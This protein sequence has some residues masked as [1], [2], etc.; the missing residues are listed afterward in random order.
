MP[1]SSLLVWLLAAGL[2]AALAAILLL[3]RQRQIARAVGARR[4]A[5]V[6]DLSG[7]LAA[8]TEALQESEARIQGFLRHAPAAIAV[9]GLDGRLLLVNRKAEA[10]IGLF[11]AATPDGCGGGLFP[12]DTLAR[13]R[14]QDARVL[15]G[16]E[17]VQ[18]E[19]TVTLPDGSV[20]DYLIQKFPLIDALDRCWGVGVIATDHTQRKESE[21]AHLQHH[22]LDALRLMAGGIAHDFNNI[23]SA[24]LGNVELARLEL[25]PM[26][27][28]AALERLLARAEALVTQ[29]LDYAGLGQPRIQPLDLNLQVGEVLWL[30]RATLPP[31]VLLH[32]EPGTDLPFMEGDGAQVKQVILNLV[33]NALEAA[34]PQG[35][36]VT[37]RTGCEAVDPAAAAHYRGQA[38][39][40]GRHLVLEVSDNGQGMPA[41]VQERSFDPFFTTKFTGRGLGLAT[42]QGIVRSH[43][44]GLRVSSAAGRGATFRVLFPAVPMAGPAVEPGPDDLPGDYRGT[45]TILVV[46]DEEPLRA[47]VARALGRM[48]FETLEARDGLEA[49]EVFGAHWDRVRLILL[50]LSMPRMGGEEAY[51]ELRKAGALAPIILTSGFRT[52]EARQRFQGMALAGFLQKPYRLRA[53]ADAIRGALED[54]TSTADRRGRPPRELVAWLPEYETGHPAMDAQHKALLRAFNQLVA[55]VETRA[56]PERAL[57]SLIET[58]AAHCAFEE[59]LRDDADHLAAHQRMLNAFREEAR[60]V[61][62]D[63]GAFTPELLNRLEDTLLNHIQ[64]EDRELARRL[65]P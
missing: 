28:L 7:Q 61:H 8:R 49:L 30:L 53:L 54:L 29:F 45:G 63:G 41:D 62:Q 32:W 48:G 35:G 58:L 50:D 42:V 24:M 34:G 12:P 20:R 38:L 60:R 9:K 40:P 31:G 43:S 39:K 37:L 11:Q 64:L 25:G 51:L 33:V 27:H 18:A 3:A 13:G 26:E 10:L 5:E 6:R 55:S 16:R 14:D 47:V 2:L 19:E 21:R 36:A 23:L 4:A 44:G 22:K 1:P 57:D 65:G 46:D 59:G 56:G 52:E 17:Q 15:S